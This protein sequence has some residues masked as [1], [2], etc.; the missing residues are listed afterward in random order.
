MY[1]MDSSTF[2]SPHRW[3]PQLKDSLGN[4]QGTPWRE[5]VDPGLGK[6]SVALFPVR[7]ARLFVANVPN[8]AILTG[9]SLASA[10]PIG[11]LARSV[12]SRFAYVR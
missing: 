2:A 12:I 3:N 8:S 1:H 5:L 10:S 6:R 9:S 7:A 11:S 4:V